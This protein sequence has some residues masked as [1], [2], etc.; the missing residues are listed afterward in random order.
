ML[1]FHDLTSEEHRKVVDPHSRPNDLA[2]ELLFKLF[3]H[4]V[5]KAV[6]SKFPQLGDTP[7]GALGRIAKMGGSVQDL[8]DD[9]H[10]YLLSVFSALDRTTGH[11]AEH[12]VDWLVRHVTELNRRISRHL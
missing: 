9:I 6:K 5:F 4:A 11:H 3:E 12:T 10:R 1:E 7:H 2:P 8:H